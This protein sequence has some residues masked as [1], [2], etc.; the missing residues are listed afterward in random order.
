MEKMINLHDICI[1]ICIMSIVITWITSDL[2][3][4]LQNVS[5]LGHLLRS[6]PFNCILCS[7][8]WVS[9]IYLYNV[10]G[11]NSAVLAAFPT[12]LIA[13]YTFKKLTS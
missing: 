1:L 12:A 2:F 7:T 5:V 3:Y 13:E 10:H 11:F 4:K 6:K 8:F 9:A